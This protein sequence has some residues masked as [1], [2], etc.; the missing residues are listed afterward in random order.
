MSYHFFT[1]ADADL[2][3]LEFRQTTSKQARGLIESRGQSFAQIC[4]DYQ[5]IESAFIKC[6]NQIVSGQANINTINNLLL[7][8]KAQINAVILANGPD[9]GCTASAADIVSV[10]EH[11]KLQKRAIRC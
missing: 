4:Q 1:V 2:M 3:C 6:E 10:L 11:Q 5:S 7:N 8:L 9:C